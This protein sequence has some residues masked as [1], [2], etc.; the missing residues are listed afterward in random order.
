[1][2]ERKIWA[3]YFSPTGTTKKVVTTVAAQLVKNMG[4]SFQE[5]DFTLP[6]ARE[7]K[8]IFS[9]QDLVVF[10]TPVIAGRVPNVL[11]KFMNT[12]EGHGALAVPVVV[13]GNRNYDDAL[14]ELR[15]ILEEDGFKT[16]AA[17]A[18]IGEHSFSTTLGAGRPD[19]K[20]LQ[21]SES[22]AENIAE[23]LK[24]GESCDIPVKVKG[25]SPLK[26]YYQ[27]RDRRGNPIDIRKVKPKT[28]ESCNECGLCVKVCPM[29]S[30]NPENVREFQGICI[31]CGAC[32]KKC[33]AGAK[34][35][36]DPGYL[37]HKEELELEYTRRAEPEIFL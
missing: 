6:N 33:P 35:Y 13:Y 37:Y 3:M 19:N 10:G 9:P 23:K 8:Y 7:K 32:I 24:A 28:K 36:D 31:K 26:G 21:K 18:F 27:P 25:N 2:K 16:I 11:L 34:F 5:I 4:V 20:D 17:G 15:D 29:G 22:F 1:M 12:L 14:I 30:I